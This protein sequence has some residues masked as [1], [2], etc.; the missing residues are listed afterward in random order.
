[1]SQTAIKKNLNLFAPLDK[2]QKY[3]DINRTFFI[4]TQN[5]IYFRYF[6]VKK[7]LSTML[8]QILTQ[9]MG[10][11]LTTQICIVIIC[12]VLVSDTVGNIAKLQINAQAKSKQIDLLAHEKQFLG[13]L[14][15]SAVI[16]KGKHTVNS[17]WD[18]HS[19]R[20]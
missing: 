10:L 11:C 1:L 7:N 16:G 9:Q 5:I 20:D 15:T 2:Y 14:E 18:A 8:W 6:F 3:N 19:R 17:R 12:K 4:S 13:S